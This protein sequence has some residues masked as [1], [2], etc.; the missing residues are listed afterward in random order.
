M[1]LPVSSV[2]RRYRPHGE[3]STTGAEE[4]TLVLESN[5][6]LIAYGS[7]PS[8]NIDEAMR[9]AENRM[10]TM[11]S[12]LC[13]KIPMWLSS[14]TSRTEFAGYPVEYQRSDRWGVLHKGRCPS[15]NGPKMVEDNCA[16]ALQLA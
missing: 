9:R 15:P 12:M 16:V 5:W 8:A 11:T 13:T 7:R 2:N 1:I 4:H 6:C 10:A 14:R 3:G